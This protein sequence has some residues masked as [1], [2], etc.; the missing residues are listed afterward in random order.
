MRRFPP[1][2]TIEENNNAYFIIRDNTGQALGYFYFEEELGRRSAAKLLSRDEARRMAA[3]FA[4]RPELVRNGLPATAGNYRS[5]AL[6]LSSIANTQTIR[7]MPQRTSGMS[8]FN[9]K[10]RMVAIP[11][12]RTAKPQPIQLK[13][14]SQ[15]FSQSD[16]HWIISLGRGYSS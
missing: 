3:N 16:E 12:R 13:E 11:I 2:W 15:E 7:P 14:D 10:A 1:P 6:Y 8:G 4:M 9:V 5:S